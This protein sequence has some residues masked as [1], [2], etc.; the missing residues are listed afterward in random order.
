MIQE[1][2]FYAVQIKAKLGTIIGEISVNNLF[3]CR[4][5]WMLIND[6]F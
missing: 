4:N 3:N 5:M 6:S 1:I 2:G